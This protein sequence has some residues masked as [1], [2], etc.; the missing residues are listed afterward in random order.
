MEAGELLGCL[1]AAQNVPKLPHPAVLY[2]HVICDMSPL[3]T[4]DR[5]T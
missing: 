4:R 3:L 5:L 2:V 1:P